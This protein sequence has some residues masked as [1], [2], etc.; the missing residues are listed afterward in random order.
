MVRSF[1][2][3]CGALCLS[4][5]APGSHCSALQAN[6][7]L[8]YEELAEGVFDQ[9]NELREAPQSL[10]PEMQA[11]LGRFRGLIL[12]NSALRI[13]TREGAGAVR[14]ALRATE[15]QQP[16]EELDR[17][18]ALQAAVDG[19]A[20]DQSR[21]GGLGHQ[22]SDGAGPFERMARQGV[23]DGYRAENI[24]YGLIDR[25]DPARGIVLQLLIDDGVRDRGH[26]KNLFMAEFR[27]SAVACAPH[28]RFSPVCVINYASECP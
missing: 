24:S 22:G 28:R 4:I 3:R 5:A 23:N 8:D 18:D 14:E 16:V 25:E 7:E 13:R 19:H 6:Q 20:A 11:M 17:C 15:R 12:T 2:L 10:N 21:S 27:Y 9:S 26:R 1:A